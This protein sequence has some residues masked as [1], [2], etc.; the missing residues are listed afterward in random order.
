MEIYKGS[1]EN[2][3]FRNYLEGTLANI[4][5]TVTVAISG[6]GITGSPVTLSV[7]KVDDGVYRATIPATAT[8]EEGEITAVWSYSTL[9][10]SQTYTVVTPYVE[11]YDLLSIC[12]SGT[13]WDDIKYSELYARNKINGVTGQSFGKFTSSESAQGKGTDYLLL[14][15]RILSINK[16]YKNN[17][18]VID[19]DGDTNTFGEDVMVS[20]S[21]YSIVI[22]RDYDVTEHRQTGIIYRGGAFRE[23]DSF[24]VNGL[25]GWDSVPSDISSCAKELVSDYWCKDNTWRESYVSKIKAGD[26]QAEFSSDVFTGT[27]N[28]YVDLIL[29]DYIWINMVVI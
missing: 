5:D 14:P 22:D 3:Y 29:T 24:V 11:T 15:K 6:D 23:E 27:G 12:P 13:S 4:T 2:I 1:P 21:K 25:Y 20:P 28:S 26:W 7:T 8:A 17:V 18:L 19:I 9:T 10:V 16:L